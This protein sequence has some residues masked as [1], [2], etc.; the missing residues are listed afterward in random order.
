MMRIPLVLAGVLAAGAAADA[1]PQAQQAKDRVVLR[2]G[3]A[4]EGSVQRDTWKEVVVAAGAPQTIKPEEILRIEYHDAPPAFRGA[5]AAIEQEK[6]QEALSS[7]SSAEELYNAA[8]KDKKLPQVRGWFPAYLA[9]H[10]GLCMLQLGKLDD[11]VRQFEKIRK[12]FKESRFLPEAYELTLQAYREKGDVTAMDAFEKEIASAPPEVQGDLKT[13]AKR[14]RAELLFDKNKYGE[15]KA[16]FE[17]LSRSTDAEA[18][19][20]GTAGVIRCLSGL[21][22]AA[23]TDAYCKRVL[24]TAT[25]PSLLLVASNAIGDAFF[26]Q[27]QYGP[28]RDA[29]VASV[30]RYNPG[31]TGTGIE[32]E[33]ERALYQL[34]RSYEE[35][36][37][38]AKDDKLKESVLVMA[39]SAY[40][41]LSSEYPSGK[42]REEAAAKAAKLEA[43]TDRKSEKK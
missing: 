27:K 28:A 33:H 37:A 25:Q 32:R 7:L 23:A 39:T 12:D 38:A 17:E 5:M 16:L 21:N 30:V 9:H 41:E 13:R 18:A 8:Q 31:R 6:W 2:K 10:R 35:L 34:A 36:A 3:T 19:T 29:Y 1:S 11:S 15:A 20:E 42:Y 14:Q 40:R 43:R 22:D 24:G 4:V 26:S